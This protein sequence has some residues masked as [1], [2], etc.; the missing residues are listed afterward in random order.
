MKNRLRV[1]GIVIVDATFLQHLADPAAAALV[2]ST[3]DLCN[4]RVYPSK[5]NAI[6]VIKDP[7]R[8]RQMRLALA[9]K[10]W[11]G[12]VPLL[13]WPP[14]LLRLAGEAALAGEPN[15]VIPREMLRYLNPSDEDDVAGDQVRADAFVRE[16]EEIFTKAH[17]EVRAELQ[18]ILKAKRVTARWATVAAFLDGEWSLTENRDY[19]TGSFWTHFGLPGEPPKD[20][21]DR[22]EA[23]RLF[24]E[25]FGASVYER[26]V[27]KE[28]KPNVAGVMDLLQL[29]YLGMHTS[30]RILI[31][32]DKSFADTGRSIL[33]GRY[34]GVR[35]MSSAEFLGKA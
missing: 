14:E 10:D 26:S 18:A 24:I 33:T 6:E 11:C 13:P 15:P 12:G 9:I 34:P 17:T 31:T 28:Q 35:V 27:S 23:W 8:K 25:A 1:P 32:D 29:V 3:C 22:S 7:S 5:I 16:S 19:F 2:R 4:L 21:F 20:L 30:S